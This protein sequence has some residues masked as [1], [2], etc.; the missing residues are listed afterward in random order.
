MRIPLEDKQVVISRVQGSYVFP[1]RVMLV[2]AMNPCACGYYPDRN[3]CHCTESDVRKYLSKISKPLLDR[4]D[5]SVEVPAISKEDLEKATRGKSSA[6]LRAEVV[7]AWEIQKERYKGEEIVFNS[8]LDG[9]RIRKYCM[10]SAEGKTLL[11]E[12]F[13]KLSLSLRA[14]DR[15]LKVSRTIADLEGEETIDTRHVAEAVSYRSV[16]RK[17]WR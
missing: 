7:G 15:I 13:E 6:D 4:V 9:A 8:E 16:D 12:A 2:L 1:T 5:I 11:R 17:F 10:L 3:K 14:Y